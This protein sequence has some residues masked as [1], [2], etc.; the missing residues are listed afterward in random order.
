MKCTS[1][2]CPGRLA[3]RSTRESD[4]P[5]RTIR[6]RKCTVCG[7]CVPTLETVL[8]IRSIPTAGARSQ[9]SEVRDQK[10]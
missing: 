4:R 7:V 3:C 6:H 5:G 8:S 10:S 9:E 1:P 2:D